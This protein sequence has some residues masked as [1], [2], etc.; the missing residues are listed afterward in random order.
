VNRQLRNLIA[1]R[2]KGMMGSASSSC[3][4]G[5]QQLYLHFL[6]SATDVGTWPGDGDSM[7]K[8]GHPS[9]A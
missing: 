1:E 5:E 3:G 2:K 4:P 7:H 8:E 6:S 9:G